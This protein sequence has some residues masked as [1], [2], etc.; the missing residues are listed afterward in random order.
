MRFKYNLELSNL[1]HPLLMVFSLF[2]VSTYVFLAVHLLNTGKLNSD[3]HKYLRE[4]SDPFEFM[5][6]MT[7]GII[8]SLFLFM[9]GLKNFRKK[10]LIE[11]IPT[12]KVRSIAMGPVE[13][14][15]KARGIYKLV[16]PYAK[17]ECVYYID[18]V[19]VLIKDKEGSRW[20]EVSRICSNLPFYLEDDTGRV[21]VNPLFVDFHFE[22]RFTTFD[23]S[24]M[25]DRRIREW[26]ILDRES[27]YLMGTAQ[28]TKN[29]A[30]EFKAKFDEA[31]RK[32]KNDKENLMRFDAN[33]DGVIDVFEWDNAAEQVKQEL[34]EKELAAAGDK[35]LPAITIGKFQDEDIFII[36]EKSE[37]ELVKHLFWKAAGFISASLI[38]FFVIM[39]V[40]LSAVTN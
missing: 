17:M 30:Q 2:A 26:F 5:A 22:P 40:L 35:Q 19:E 23:N 18:S 4:L 12:S 31:L 36:S 27:V 34:L 39:S 29:I 13:L 1:K 3:A 8:S 20:K 14:Q 7:A 15:G 37:K 38:I 21:I 28:S 24:S 16:S 10:N 32:L 33:K 25:H 9:L 11:D 6:G